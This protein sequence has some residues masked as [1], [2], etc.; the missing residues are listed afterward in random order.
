VGA[1]IKTNGEDRKPGP[2]GEASGGALGTM[3]VDF[4][5]SGVR[6]SGS[7]NPQNIPFQWSDTA[8][9]WG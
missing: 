7:R 2:L 4:A 9:S 3:Y 6:G 5:F 8:S 1:S